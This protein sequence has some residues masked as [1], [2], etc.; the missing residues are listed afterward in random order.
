MASPVIKENTFNQAFRDAPVAGKRKMLRTL[1]N[2]DLRELR[3]QQFIDG[4]FKWLIMNAEELDFPL[5]PNASANVNK[6]AIVKLAKISG[7]TWQKLHGYACGLSK[8]LDAPLQTVLRLLLHLVRETP[9]G[10]SRQEA[11]TCGSTIKTTD[12]VITKMFKLAITDVDLEKFDIHVDMS[13]LTNHAHI[14]SFRSNL[15]GSFDMVCKLVEIARLHKLHGVTVTPAFEHTKA[16]YERLGFVTYT[17]DGL[18]R[19][20]LK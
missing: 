4:D 10:I 19:I 20:S 7:V 18:M 6:G 15:P 16:F 8:R 14:V 5:D 11:W 2:G 12:S 17:A 9:R 13:L 3:Q 1:L